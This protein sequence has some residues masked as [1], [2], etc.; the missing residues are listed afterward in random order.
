MSYSSL[1]SIDKDWNGSEVKTYGN[2]HLF[3]PIVWDI[4]MCKHI[5]L[6][7]RKLKYPMDIDGKKKEYETH[8]L[9]WSMPMFGENDNFDRL[10]EKI[11]NCQVQV[12]RVLWELSNLSVFNVKDKDFVAD[13]IEK[14]IELNFANSE[15]KD[16]E[17]IKTRF[18]E[19]A[20]DIRELPNK[21]QYFVFKGTSCDDNVEY[22]FCT[23]DGGEKSLADWDKFV[24]EFTIIENNCIV[25]FSDN[26]KMCEKC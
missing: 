6:E 7:E 26:L 9:I 25:K 22:W 12:D 23:D 4:L 13:C 24:C 20:K 3:A 8:F 17:H 10:N 19:V 1:W 16:G 15:Y 21:C 14:F 2:S 5:P 18:R 11:N